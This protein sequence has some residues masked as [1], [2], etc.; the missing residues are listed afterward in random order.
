MNELQGLVDALAAELGQPVDVDDRHHRAIAYSSHRDP[1][2]PVRLA[3]I[4]QRE[5]PREVTDWLESLGIRDAAEPVH[6]PANPRFG[7]AARV[8]LPIRF[9]GTLLGYLWL[10]E[11]PE[12]LTVAQLEA[13]VRCAGELAV[14]LARERQLEL[15]DRERKRELLGRLLGDDAPGTDAADAAAAAA[16]LVGGGF[17]AAAPAY[18][19][20]V[21]QPLHRDRPEPSDAVRVRIVGAVDQLRRSVAPH[22]ALVRIGADRID[23][24]LACASAGD[25]DRRARRLAETVERELAGSEGWSALVAAGDE[26]ATVRELRD[27]YA[28]AWVALRVARAVEGFAPLARWAD[29]GAYRT[30]ATLLGDGDPHAVPAPALAR[31]L[32]CPDAATLVPTLERYLDLGGDAR[33]AAVALYL[34]R[35]SLYGRLRRIEEV[36]GVDL[37][38]GEDRLELHMAL[39]L[40]RLGGGTTAG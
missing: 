17:L 16:E 6:V 4:L 28:E 31:L 39:R 11:E 13:A 33:A 24:V 1:V 34:H 10:I 30:L 27:A 14:T 12:P 36:A 32:A 20:L 22:H 25:A 35:S 2:D 8:C 21:V 37:R 15:G 38:T 23:V 40:W 3:S 5:A 26:R 19:V 18:A 29:L 7:M 9:D